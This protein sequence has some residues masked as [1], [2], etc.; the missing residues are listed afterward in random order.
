MHIHLESIPSPTSC[1]SLMTPINTGALRV[2][3]VKRDQ[4]T[5]QNPVEICCVQN[6][7]WDPTKRTPILPV[8]VPFP[9]YLQTQGSAGRGQESCQARSPCR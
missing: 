1:F 5:S 2:S 3:G 9:T 6:M 7:L 4:S 8:T